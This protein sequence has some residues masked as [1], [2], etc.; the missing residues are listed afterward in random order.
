MGVREWLA[1]RFGAGDLGPSG[2][3]LPTVYNAGGAATQNFD[4]MNHEMVQRVFGGMASKSGRMVNESSVMS[5]SAAWGCMRV[6]SE[7]IGAMPWAVFEEDGQGNATKVDHELTEVLVHSP[8]FEMTGV[9]MK[10]AVALNLC[11]A[12]NAYC[13]QERVG[14]RV[15]SLTPVESRLMTP[16]QKRGSNTKL[17]LPEGRVFF[18]YTDRGKPDDLPREKVWHVKGFGSNGIEGLSPLTAAREAMGFALATEEFGNRFFAQGAMP[19]GIVTFPGWLKPEQRADAEAALAKMV[20]GLGNA[21]QIALFQGGMKPEPW[22]SVPLKDLEFLL[23]RQFSV[24]EVCR[25][26]RVPPHMVADLSRATFSNIEHLSQEFVMFTLLPYFVRVE[27][28]ISKWLMRPRDRK[29]YFVRFNA[30]G[31]LR[32]DSKTRAEYL[33]TMVNAGIMHRNEARGK[34]NLNRATMKNMDAFT[35]Q[36]A[37][38]TIDKL[39]EQPAPKPAP[40]PGRPQ[41]TDDQE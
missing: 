31:L 5:I 22:G 4:A 36:T 17:K 10:E 28:S 29:R 8:N 30:D 40:K 15:V 20:G 13:L 24:P 7:T 19:A 12:G 1:A 27:A 21:H 39:G 34:E 35:V 33:S 23:L 6:L 11:Q 32:A 14:E 16:M 38:T 3:R 25:F 18:R 2:E 41:P 9:E 26:Y 37:M